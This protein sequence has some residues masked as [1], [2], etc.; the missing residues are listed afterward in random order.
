MTHL[1]TRPR[2]AVIGAGIAGSACAGAL[3]KAGMDVTLFDKS[4]G[5]GGRMATRRA[6]WPGHDG[7]PQ[8]V[9][10]D[11]GAP[12]FTAD[13]PRF[14]ALLKRAESVGCVARWR[15]NVHLQG[16]AQTAREAYVALPTMSAL[17]RHLLAGVSLRF[18]Q[19]VQRLQ[20]D[21]QG[22]HVVL[23]GMQTV[24]PFDQV[25]V[26]IPAPQAAPLL[27]GHR[28]DWAQTLAQVRMTSGWTLM[29]VTPDVDWPWDAAESACGP[30][31][32]VIRQ[33][34]KPGRTALHGRA[35]W[36]AHASPA[37]SAAHLEDSA[38]QVGD[39]LG[40][41]LRKMLAIAAGPMDW[42]H[43]SA[44]RWRF[45][46]PTS[47]S[48]PAGDCWWDPGLGLGVCGDFP[49]G[50]CVESAWRSGDELA[51]TLLAAL[52]SQAADQHV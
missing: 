52:E 6:A 10:L 28:D 15:P 26:A 8:W 11:H 24:G 29:A 2:I 47:S 9:D 51:D 42:P 3:Q 27:A 22:W 39:A 40:E 38:Q 35:A 7:A 25:V 20:R 32:W 49:G 46:W 30:L 23:Q 36:V 45:A 21:A 4:R 16:P 19:P 14:R 13:Q 48:V 44:H 12:W 37:W 50:G 17:C 41:A 43:V 31:E 1:S 5:A 34:R 33:D 18:E